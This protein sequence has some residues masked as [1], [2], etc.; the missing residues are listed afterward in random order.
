MQYEVHAAWL[1]TQLSYAQKSKNSIENYDMC[2][3]VQLFQ[4]IDYANHLKLLDTEYCTVKALQTG[5]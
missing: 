4:I 1:P 5:V 3:Q 2:R